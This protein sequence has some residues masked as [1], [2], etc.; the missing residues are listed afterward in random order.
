MEGLLISFHQNNIWLTFNIHPLIGIMAFELPNI[1]SLLAQFA[2][3]NLKMNSI[4][5]ILTRIDLLDGP[6]TFVSTHNANSSMMDRKLVYIFESFQFGKYDRLQ[7]SS[8][9]TMISSSLLM[10]FLSATLVALHFTPVSESVS[11]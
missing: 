5:I 8:V 11:E 6:I 1:K 9:D 7:L 3:E 2:Q 4:V 10:W